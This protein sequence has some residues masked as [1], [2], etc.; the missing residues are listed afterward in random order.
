MDNETWVVE[1]GDRIV[2]K[3]TRV[4]VD[5]LTDWE[6]LVYWLWIAD[7][8]MRNAGDLGTARDVYAD[9]QSV[10]LHSAI[11][12]SLPTTISA[13]MLDPDTLQER[14]FD[15]FDAVCAEIRSAEPGVPLFANL[16]EADPVVVE[17]MNEAKRTFLQFLDALSKMRFS[18]AS[19]WV[20][21]PFIDRSDIRQQALVRTVETAAEYHS[22][23]TC[24]L[25]LSVNSILDDLIF[26]TVAEAPEALQLTNGTSFV[27]ASDSIEDW[28]INQDGTV[29]GG[30]SLQV[31]RR[32][33]RKDGQLKFD[34]HTG[35][36]EF[37]NLTPE[38]RG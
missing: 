2:L 29:Y 37:R 31:I 9:F 36:H 7:Y 5:R 8:G 20:K 23:P 25:W 13:F 34:A 10:A 30:F 24:H 1:E 26:C 38:Q 33:L 11:K 18:Q 3:K 35:I 4:G 21:V 6:R 16:S 12:L 22:R 19:Y 15:L 17:A 28:M 32:S 27:V 14:Y